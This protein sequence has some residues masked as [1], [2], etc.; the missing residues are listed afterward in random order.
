MKVETC[1]VVDKTSIK[2]MEEALAEAFDVPEITEAYIGIKP[3]KLKD[4][5]IAHLKVVLTVE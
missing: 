5:R 2:D 4:G 3:V 1:V